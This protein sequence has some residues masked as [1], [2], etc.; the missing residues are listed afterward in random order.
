MAVYKG[1]RKQKQWAYGKQ[2]TAL[3]YMAI[4]N[5]DN[6]HMSNSKKKIKKRQC[7]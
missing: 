6:G 2:K 1:N 7:A 4:E 3:E 5:R